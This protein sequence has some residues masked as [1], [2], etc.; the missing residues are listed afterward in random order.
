[1]LQKMRVKYIVVFSL[2]LSI[3]ISVGL[4]AYADT[5]SYTVAN[6]EDYFGEY[7]ESEYF[8]IEDFINGP[9]FRFNGINVNEF[10]TDAIDQFCSKMEDLQYTLTPIGDSEVRAVFFE[11]GNAKILLAY[12]YENK[13]LILCYQANIAF[14]FEESEQASGGHECIICTGD[15]VC[16]TCH[17]K[18]TWFDNTCF[19]CK[20]KKTCQTCHGDGYVETNENYGDVPA[21]VCALCRGSG[22]CQVCYGRG[23]FFVA[24]YGQGGS[25]YVTCSG[26]N[27]N[28]KCKYC[29]GTGKD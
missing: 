2:L 29:E 4:S 18:G 26:C 27:G 1:M 11:K 21:G 12:F 16:S 15:G 22:I 14:T 5:S 6:P 17:G 8:E 3:A 10:G 7:S 23:R 19:E 24:T 13:E 9:G 20:G 25:N 28:R